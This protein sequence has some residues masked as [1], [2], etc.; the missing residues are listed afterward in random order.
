MSKYWIFA[1]IAL[2]LMICSTPI[3]KAQNQ[4]AYI[5][6]HV[7]WHRTNKDNPHIEI[8]VC[9]DNPK[10]EHQ[11]YRD[12]V[13]KAIEN[14]WQKYSALKFTKWCTASEEDCDI[15]IYINDTV[16]HTLALGTDIR[17]KKGGMVLNFAFEKWS[18]RCK[19]RFEYCVQAIAVHEFGHALGFSHEHNRKDCPTENC[20]KPPEG[21]R[22]DWV[23]G[24]CDLQS[25]MYYCNPHY[26]NDGI[27]SKQDIKA[28]QYLYS[29]PPNRSDEYEGLTVVYNSSIKDSVSKALYKD[30]KLYLSGNQEDLDK[31]DHVLYY[32]DPQWFGWWRR[33]IISKKRESNFGLGLSLYRDVNVVAFVFSNDGSKTLKETMIPLTVHFGDQ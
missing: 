33:Q 29:L 13:K 2:G 20:D 12:L 31:V 6:E 24:P 30:F 26:N 27:L 19:A 1:L 28:V 16:P 8:S 23:I 4:N 10:P 17:N 5:L 11:Q 15:H 7:L 32:I 3:V 14:T 9:W 25:V 21:D 22:G 18:P